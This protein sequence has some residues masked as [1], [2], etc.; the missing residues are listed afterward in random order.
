M[1]SLNNLFIPLIVS[2]FA[3]LIA[4]PLRLYIKK[5]FNTFRNKIY[6]KASYRSYNIGLSLNLLIIGFILIIGLLVTKQVSFENNLKDLAKDYSELKEKNSVDNKH[7]KVEIK[8]NEIKKTITTLKILNFLF[9]VGIYIVI[10]LLTWN[11]L[12]QK[13]INDLITDFERKLKILKPDIT[14]EEYE[15]IEKEFASME[16]L[17]D[18]ELINSK[19]EENIIQ[20]DE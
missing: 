14:N 4:K 7:E 1:D 8:D 9:Q 11:Y 17:E 19:I 13:H 6:K 20:A 16:T 3:S 5:R 10:F 18:Y 2:L 15:R 12:N